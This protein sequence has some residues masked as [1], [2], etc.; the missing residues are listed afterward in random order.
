M[1]AASST[2]AVSSA[3]PT[4]G[5]GGRT[6]STRPRAS[7]SATCCCGADA[8]PGIVMHSKCEREQ[9]RRKLMTNNNNKNFHILNITLN[10]TLIK[11][12][13]AHL[14]YI[15]FFCIS[16]NY[17]TSFAIFVLCTSSPFPSLSALT[18]ETT[19]WPSASL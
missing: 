15:S 7:R 12:K 9:L 6:R 18:T 5:T 17:L 1:S 13:A 19:V 11:S 2:P 14:D 8:K 10:Q 4:C 3:F 16:L